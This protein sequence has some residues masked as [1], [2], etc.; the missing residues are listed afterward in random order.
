MDED[1]PLLIR[2]LDDNDAVLNK[3]AVVL[4]NDGTTEMR[5]SLFNKYSG[6]FF[7][8][9]HSGYIDRVLSNFNDILI[10]LPNP[11]RTNIS[12]NVVYAPLPAT[13]DPRTQPL[14]KISGSKSYA[15]SVLASYQKTIIDNYVSMLGVDFSEYTLSG[16]R[17]SGFVSPEDRVIDFT[18]NETE[19]IENH[20]YPIFSP[21][22]RLLYDWVKRV[23]FISR[24]QNYVAITLDKAGG[25]SAWHRGDMD[26]SDAV[27]LP[28]LLFQLP[29][30]HP[31]VFG[32]SRKRVVMLTEGLNTEKVDYLNGLSNCLDD[33]ICFVPPENKLNLTTLKNNLIALGFNPNENIS[34]E[35][36]KNA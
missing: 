15:D 30:K 23:L 8:G 7:V 3:I 1:T 4:E 10:G 6:Q 19:V 18:V 36:S 24:D 2:F 5:D 26:L 25:V 32:I 28:N 29:E 11:L 22:T 17:S 16:A 34:I 31:A 21:D 9:A 20:S 12:N 13:E 14:L 33:H 35:T 27:Y